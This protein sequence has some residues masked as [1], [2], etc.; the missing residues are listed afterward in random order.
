MTDVRINARLDRAA[1]KK[2]A[3]LKKRTGLTTSEILRA[4]LEQ[5]YAR[6]TQPESSAREI[7]AQTG[8]VG[9]AAGTEDLSTSYKRSLGKSLERKL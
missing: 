4:A 5:F 7:L 6:Q 8:F 1:S 2:L 9:C 3:L